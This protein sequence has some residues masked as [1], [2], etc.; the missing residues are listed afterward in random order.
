VRALAPSLYRDNGH[1]NRSAD[2]DDDEDDRQ[3]IAQYRTEFQVPLVAFLEVAQPLPLLCLLMLQ[4]KLILAS[5]PAVLDRDPFRHSSASLGIGPVRTGHC[6]AKDCAKAHQEDDQ[7]KQRLC[8]ERVVD[9]LSFLLFL[10][11]LT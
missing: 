3:G 10:L 5:Y 11:A 2:A 7:P 1:T 9:H 8:K 4:G 6:Q